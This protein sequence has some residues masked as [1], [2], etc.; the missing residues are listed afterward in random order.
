MS[1]P[2][3]TTRAPPAGML[4]TPAPRSPHLRLGVIQ[5]GRQVNEP[6]LLSEH[7]Q[8]IHPRKLLVIVA[9][10]LAPRCTRAASVALGERCWIPSSAWSRMRTAH[11]ALARSVAQKRRPL[12][13]PSQNSFSVASAANRA[14]ES[15]VCL[16]LGPRHSIATSVSSCPRK[17][18]ES[19][20]F[21]GPAGERAQVAMG[22]D[23]KEHKEVREWGFQLAR[24][25]A[26]SRGPK[27]VQL[28]GGGAGGLH[29]RC[30]KARSAM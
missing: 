10:L 6:V 5:R 18:P 26:P 19:R 13:Y 11:S 12:F 25:C 23:E 2:W 1:A 27:E 14:S 24:G 9:A 20:E 17:S 29:P 7:A 22:G 21:G 28:V 16:Q 4:A 8:V 15:A 3:R 30:F